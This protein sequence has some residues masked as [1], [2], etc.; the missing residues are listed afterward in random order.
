LEPIENFNPVEATTVTRVDAA[1]GVSSV[2]P[3]K[4]T[5]R[6]DPMTPMEG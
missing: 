2:E 3:P 4:A 5:E 6:K 1:A